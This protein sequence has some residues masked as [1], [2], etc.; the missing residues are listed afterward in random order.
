M[1]RSAQAERPSAAFAMGERMTRAFRHQMVGA[2]QTTLRDGVHTT[3][4]IVFK[5]GKRGRKTADAVSMWRILP[6]VSKLEEHLADVGR[7]L[8]P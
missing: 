3:V 1:R 7:V 5:P 4:I 2:E 8:I 6:D